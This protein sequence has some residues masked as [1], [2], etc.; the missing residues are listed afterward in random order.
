M[1][2]TA[3]VSTANNF[4]HSIDGR[5]DLEPLPQ[6]SLHP[7]QELLR[8]QLQGKEP[9]DQLLE[10]SVLSGNID[11]ARKY[12]E[13]IE[14]TDFSDAAIYSSTQQLASEALD[15]EISERL[16]LADFVEDSKG[17]Q[18]PPSLE[19]AALIG[20][21]W[22]QLRANRT[23][24][25]DTILHVEGILAATIDCLKDRE[26]YKAFGQAFIQARDL[27]EPLAYHLQMEFSKIAPNLDAHQID[28]KRMK[29]QKGQRIANYSPDELDSFEQDDAVKYNPLEDDAE[30]DDVAAEIADEVSAV[31]K[32]VTTS[33]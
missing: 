4:D 3:T 29:K 5:P 10:T 25:E 11:N 6:S 20:Q 12:Q 27:D 21:A 8:L 33:H 17:F 32:I 28:S 1:E 30:V 13:I 9:Y 19:A 15:Q 24:S 26:L 22:D 7:A 18:R 2:R 31:S 23:L 14:S 16:G